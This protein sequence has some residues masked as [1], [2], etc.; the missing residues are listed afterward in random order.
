MSNCCSSLRSD[1]CLVVGDVTSTMAC[2]IAA[3]KLR[4]PVAHVEGGIRSGDWGMPEEINRLVTDA[5]TNGSSR[6]AKSPTPT[7]AA[8][9][10]RDERHLLRRQHDDRHTAGQSDR[11]CARRRSGL[12]A[13]STRRLLRD[14]IASAGQR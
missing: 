5:I 1:L 11:G 7:C 2:A 4:V 6:P 10:S 12:A 14:D 3:Q 8:A 9:G 13:L